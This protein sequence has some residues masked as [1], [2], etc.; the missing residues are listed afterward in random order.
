MILAGDLDFLGFQV[1]D[2]VVGTAVAEFQFKRGA[3][4]GQAEDL[5]T[6]ADARMG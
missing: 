6:Q 4:Q 1:F 3:A 5:M 2:G